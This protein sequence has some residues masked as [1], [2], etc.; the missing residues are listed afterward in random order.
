MT[1]THYLNLSGYKFVATPVLQL[2]QLCAQLK[3]KAEQLQVKG[4]ILL[5]TEGINASLAGKAPELHAFIAYVRSFSAYHDLEFKESV[6]EAMPFTKLVVRIKPEIVTMGKDA[7]CP[8]K[9]TAPYLAPEVLKQWYEEEKDFVLLDARNNYEFAVGT[10]DEAIELNMES[11]REFP[12]AVLS[13][14][15]AMK[16]KAVVTFCTGGIRCEKAAEFM[17]QKG[18]QQVYQLEGGILNYFEKVGGDHFH[19]DCFVFDKRLTVNTALQATDT[20]TCYV[21]QETALD[22]PEISDCPYCSHLR[23]SR[24]NA[25]SAVRDSAF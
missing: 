7:V 3:E 15:Q 18:F 4:T 21:H 10:F 1:N 5:G 2:Q 23:E 14:P 19:G 16:D 8:Q 11:F 9:H 20:V 13:L 25:E 24:Q 6:S 12:D 17:L 22:A